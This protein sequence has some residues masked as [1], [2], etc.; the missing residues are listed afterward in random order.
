MSSSDGWPAPLVVRVISGFNHHAEPVWALQ[1]ISARE[2]VNVKLPSLSAGVRRSGGVHVAISG[3]GVTPHQAFLAGPRLVR[4]GPG[5]DDSLPKGC[6]DCQPAATDDEIAACSSGCVKYCTT[7]NDI[8]LECCRQSECV[9]QPR[10]GD[11]NLET[12]PTFSRRCVDPITGAVTSTPC[13]PFPICFPEFEIDL[14]FP[15]SNRCVKICCTSFDASTCS[16]S[17]REC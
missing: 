1:S 7:G 6:T 2:D 11:C 12:P 16:A 9:Q 4:A 3:R 8:A 10:C 13:N 5:G 15:I 14:P 17:V